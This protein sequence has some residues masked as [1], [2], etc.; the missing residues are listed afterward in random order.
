MFVKVSVCFDI[1]G[2]SA[3][4]KQGG[5]SCQYVL[6]AAVLMSIGRFMSCITHHAL[7]YPYKPKRGSHHVGQRGMG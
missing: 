2:R 1:A 5:L 6:F 7:Y 4:E 3:V